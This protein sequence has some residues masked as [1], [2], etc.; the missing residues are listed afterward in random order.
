MAS[1][2]HRK[3]VFVEIQARPEQFRPDLVGDHPRVRAEQSRDA[4][5]GRQRALG[6]KPA[7]QPFPFLA[8]V[9]E[10]PDRRELAFLASRRQSFADA[11]FKPCGPLHVV[12]DVHP[13]HG[14]D[15]CRAGLAG[16]C[17]RVRG[18]GMLSGDPPADLEQAG[19]DV[20]ACA[21]R[22][23]RGRVPA[24]DPLLPD[25]CAAGRPG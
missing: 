25:R 9:E 5:R 2:G 16:P 7:R 19:A 13:V 18:F 15:P 24:I 22:Q 20:T 12:S 4:A 17:R 6:V 21:G 14:C 23:R 3:I 1:L 10:P 8:V 11:I